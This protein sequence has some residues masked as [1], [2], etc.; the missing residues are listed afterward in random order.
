M[1]DISHPPF[2]IHLV[3]T[4]EWLYTHFPNRYEKVFQNPSQTR[5]SQLNSRL[6]IDL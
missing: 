2:I 3:F 4:E 1:T 6:S 5:P